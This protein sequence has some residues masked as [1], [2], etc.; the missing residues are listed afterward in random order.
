MRKSMQ[1]NRILTALLSVVLLSQGCWLRS[2]G[3]AAN[4][5]ADSHLETQIILQ[6]ADK[7]I[8]E[9]MDLNL[10]SPD[11]AIAATKWG[12]TI[13]AAQEPVIIE[14]IKY[15]KVVDGKE[16]LVIDEIGRDRLIR[17]STSF[18]NVTQTVI[19]QATWPGLSS[20]AKIRISTTLAALLPIVVQMVDLAGKFKTVKGTPTSLRSLAGTAPVTDIGVCLD[21]QTFDVPAGTRNSLEL[22][23]RQIQH[24][25]QA[26][27]RVKAKAARR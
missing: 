25:A 10:I 3:T 19:Q 2:G 22:L 12:Q 7:I 24:S 26:E 23:Q 11:V 27:A 20:Q 21:C 4:K 15:L 8:N 17:L 18:L 1:R 9:L 13:N 16:I 5:F 6:E 14:A